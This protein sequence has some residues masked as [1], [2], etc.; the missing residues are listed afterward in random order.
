MGVGG[1]DAGSV[2]DGGVDNMQGAI[3]DCSQTAHRPLVPR[4]NSRRIVPLLPFRSGEP[5]SDKQKKR[6]M[7]M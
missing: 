4:L 3:A 7:T 5:V 6:L 1:L 2:L